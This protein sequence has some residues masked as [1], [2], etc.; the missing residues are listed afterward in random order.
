M[1]ITS[2]ININSINLNE[3]VKDKND[4]INKLV[5]IMFKGGNIKDKELYKQAIL[6]RENLSTTGIGNEIAIPHAKTSAVLNTGIAI[7]IVKDGVDYEALDGEN[8]KLF[9]MIGAPDTGEDEHLQV[10]S[11]LSTLIMNPK[12]KDNILNATSPQEV[13]NIIDSLEEEKFNTENKD[14]QEN[15]SYDVLCVTA[16]PTVLLWLL[17]PLKTKLKNVALKL[18]LKQMALVVLKMF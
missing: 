1:K 15:T 16:C 5:D 7:M 10:L 2:L 11:K 13:L 18:K 12:F 4:A 3:T 14:V 9:F 6:E 8:T 17:K